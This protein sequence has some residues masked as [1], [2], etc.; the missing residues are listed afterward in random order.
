[1]SGLTLWS[2]L[3]P[4]GYVLWASPRL[5]HAPGPLHGLSLC[6]EHCPVAGSTLRSSPAAPPHVC[7]VGRPPGAGTTQGSLRGWPVLP[8]P[9][10]GVAQAL[11]LSHLV[12]KVGRAAWL[13]G[14]SL[15]SPRRAGQPT[16][17]L[18]NSREARVTAE[19]FH[20]QD[21]GFPSP[22]PDRG[23]IY[24]PGEAGFPRPPEKE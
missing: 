14:E 15:L 10:T 13:T 24:R 12:S 4:L 23:L 16:C 21:E 6:L 5:L 3:C 19:T 9:G 20:G 17:L 8:T 7:R 11:W 22:S 1:M 2:P 18:I